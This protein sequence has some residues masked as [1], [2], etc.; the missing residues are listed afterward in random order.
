MSKTDTTITGVYTMGIFVVMI[1]LFA[2]AI[3]FNAWMVMLAWG[4]AYSYGAVIGT[5][6]FSQ[7]IPFSVVMGLGMG[8]IVRA[9]S[10]RND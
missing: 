2:A 1:T 5:L 6:S 4:M 7:A 8:G 3:M 10:S 9:S